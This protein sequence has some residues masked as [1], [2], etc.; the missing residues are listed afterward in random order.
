MNELLRHLDPGACV[1]DLGCGYGSFAY[2]NHPVRVLALDQYVAD[3]AQAGRRMAGG[4]I[5]Y[6]LGTA[7]RL[8]LAGASVD[9]VIANH[10]FEHVEEPGQVAAEVSR[11]LKP[12]G[13]LFA[14]VPDG[15]S[16]SDGLYRW[17]TGGGGHVQ[18][19][20][21]PGFQETV[22]SVTD[23]ALLYSYRLYSSFSFLNPNPAAEPFFPPRSQ[24]LKHLPHL[25]HVSVLS[26]INLFTRVTDALLDARL[27]LY[28][29]AFYFGKPGALLRD[30]HSE[31]N[32]NVCAICGAG[33]SLGWMEQNRKVRR[34]YGLPTYLCEVC[35]CRNL[36][37][38]RGFTRPILN[39]G[40]ADNEIESPD[41]SWAPGLEV[42]EEPAAPSFINRD[43]LVNAAS[44]TPALAPGTLVA[45]F[46]RNLAPETRATEG[47]PWPLELA[48]VQ[49]LVNRRA[50][51]LSYASPEQI[52][53]HLPCDVPRG[54]A[55]F[56]VLVKGV[57]GPARRALVT[58]TAPA[59]FGDSPALHAATGK[60]V[61]EDNP[62]R[63]GE[64][65]LLRAIGLGPVVPPLP[66]GQAC[67]PAPAF[68]TTRRPAV[69]IGGRRVEVQFCGLAPGSIGVYQVNVR[70]PRVASG[71][72]VPVVLSIGGRRSNVVTVAVG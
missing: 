18:R 16:F 38:G 28:G 54:A 20:T 64:W 31:E 47:A 50:V 22:E 6:L 21:F 40:P 30:V 15:F 12:A 66:A 39:S 55:S 70:V 72:E 27:S 51:P 67:P 63:P 44:F 29:W 45:V 37:F 42:K 58:L 2:E 60:P 17:W 52:V 13:V 71:P 24:W 7:L 61:T 41:A 19:F 57:L 32:L 4:R 56:E 59:L 33:H 9:L 1:L 11:V 53:A 10:V 46:G 14:T 26:G 69:W 65:T 3:P 35:G 34:R 8:P 49:L 23:L 68:R 5:H 62:A 48:G 36:Y 25:A 43:G